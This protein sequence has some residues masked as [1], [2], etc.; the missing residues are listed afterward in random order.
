MQTKVSLAENKRSM[1]PLGGRQMALGG[2]GNLT[3]SSEI[4]LNTYTNS[5][6]MYTAQ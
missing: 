4:V 1:S 6:Y 3:R 2:R 5:K